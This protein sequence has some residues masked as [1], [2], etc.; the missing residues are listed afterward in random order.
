MDKPKSNKTKLI[1]IILA[2]LVFIIVLS[3]ILVVCIKGKSKDGHY[4]IFDPDKRILHYYVDERYEFFSIFEKSNY[5][6]ILK[7]YIVK[8]FKE[9]CNPT[10]ESEKDI[11][12]KEEIKNLTSVFDEIFNNTNNKEIKVHKEELTNEQNEI[13]LIIL[14][15][16]GIIQKI[17]YKILYNNDM[18]NSTYSKRGYSLEKY[19]NKSSMVTINMGNKKLKAIL[20]LYKKLK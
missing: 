17:N 15:N 10:T 5:F 14:K 8:C 12:D 11:K 18:H 13:I 20:Y 6:R 4:N 19:E 7:K 2:I 9:P 16:N 3:I 1:I